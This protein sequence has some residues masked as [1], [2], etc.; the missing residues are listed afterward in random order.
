MAFV[1]SF[2]CVWVWGYTQALGVCFLYRHRDVRKALRWVRCGF[3]VP[4]RDVAI[5]NLIHIKSQWNSVMSNSVEVGDFDVSMC[6]C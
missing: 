3:K 5:S 4:C 6:S 1:V 2:L